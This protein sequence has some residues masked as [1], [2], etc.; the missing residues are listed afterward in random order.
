MSDP[1]IR[2]EHLTKAYRLGVINHGTLRY[3]LESWWARM[4]GKDD[5]H[6][7]LSSSHI[8][9]GV[10]TFLALDDI[11]FDVQ[12]GE[13]LGIIG[14][15]GAGKST[16]LKILS[17]ITDPTSGSLK[18]KGRVASLLEVGTGFHPELTGR[19][20]IFLNGAVLGMT[21]AEIARRFDE[22]VAFSGVEKFLDTPVKRY[23]SGMY[24]R[25]AFG[26]AAHLEP[27]ILIVDEVLAVGDAEFQ[28]K[29]L[30][31]MAEVGREGRTILFVS[32]NMTAVQNLCGSALLLE[33]GKIVDTGTASDVVDRYLNES[34][35]RSLLSLEGRTDRQG[36][37]AIRFV[38]LCLHNDRDEEVSQ[39]HAGQCSKLLIQFRNHTAATLR[40][41]K[42]ALRIDGSSGERLAHLSTEVNNLDFS[43][44]P[45]EANAVEIRIPRLP[46][47]P[48]SYVV[49]AFCSVGGVISDWVQ[50]AGSFQVAEGDFFQTG[51]LPPHGQGSLLME[52][53]FEIRVC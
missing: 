9:A 43:S 20:N 51:R 36:D 22:I 45:M 4:R 35:E 13:I 11:S 17:R 25:L 5:P 29:C 34:F 47:M 10:T 19:E 38:S 2:V 3:D 48:G 6:G 18:L 44:V 40:D 32:H 7:K 42:I 28:K 53:S 12:R 46:L 39:F 23:S 21:K 15:N 1:V 30:G 24:V 8:D 14:R 33:Y 41:V 31:K 26:V 37:G 49:T 16:L 52:H 50:H 27:E